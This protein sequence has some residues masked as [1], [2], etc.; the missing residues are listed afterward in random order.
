MASDLDPAIHMHST[1]FAGMTL[2]RGFGVN[3]IQFITIFDHFD[4]IL[5]QPLQFARKWHRRVSS[6]FAATDM[7]MCGPSCDLHNRWRFCVMARKRT[8]GKVTGSQG[9]AAIDTWMF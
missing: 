3:Y 9:D 7:V 1:M 4:M 8:A 5:C 6:F 2:D